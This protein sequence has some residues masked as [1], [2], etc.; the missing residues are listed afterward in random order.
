MH[1]K[2]TNQK[3]HYVDNEMARRNACNVHTFLFGQHTHTYE[4]QN[5]LSCKTI[6]SIVSSLFSIKIHYQKRAIFRRYFVEGCLLNITLWFCV[7]VFASKCRF[8]HFC[9]FACLFVCLFVR[10]A[11]GNKSS[12]HKKKSN[13]YKCV[14]AHRKQHS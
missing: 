7:R 9:L 14:A 3:W 13:Y 4:S 1:H 8:S 6:V 11:R 2:I 10:V 5:T 12:D